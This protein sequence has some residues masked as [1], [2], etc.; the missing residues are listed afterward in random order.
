MRTG[1][2]EK[3][4]I[5]ALERYFNSKGFSTYANAH[6]NI[7][8]GTV[9]S[10]VDLLL[11]RKKEVIAIEVKSKKD[12]FRRAFVQLEKIASF[13][14]KAFVA[15]DDEIIANK[16]RKMDSYI[17]ILYV[18]L[19]SPDIVTKK[20]AKNYEINPSRTTISYLKRCCLEEFAKELKIASL[21]VQTI[22]C[23]RYTTHCKTQDVK[24]TTERHRN[25]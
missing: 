8:W 4:I 11:I 21:P 25:C 9:I 22:S 15:T 24:G 2:H 19:K 7:A 1:I 13:I 16:F 3:P 20:P 23:F 14:D 12:V 18:N 10:D 6:L 17:G 5:L